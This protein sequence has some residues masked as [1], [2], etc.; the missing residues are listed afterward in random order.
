MLC[1]ATSHPRS[2][3]DIGGLTKMGAHSNRCVVLEVHLCL[4]WWT[5]ANEDFSI[6]PSFEWDL[7]SRWAYFCTDACVYHFQCGVE[8]ALVLYLFWVRWPTLNANAVPTSTVFARF[9]AYLNIWGVRQCHFSPVR[10]MKRT[11]LLCSIVLWK[12]WKS[13]WNYRLTI[14]MT[15][16]WLAP[17]LIHIDDTHMKC[18]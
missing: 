14:V 16:T 17:D 9:G 12:W 1:G 8:L 2:F 3:A 18:K 10:G 7:Q 13:L 4:H 11:V 15:N 6:T 5:P